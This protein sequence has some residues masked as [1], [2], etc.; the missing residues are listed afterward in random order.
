[1]HLRLYTSI[2]VAILIRGSM[3]QFSKSMNL[4]TAFGRG[5]LHAFIADFTWVKY[6]AM[7]PPTPLIKGGTE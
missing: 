4:K 2:Y 3:A 5:V 6:V 1:M 7:I